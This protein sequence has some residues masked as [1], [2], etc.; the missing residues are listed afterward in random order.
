MILTERSCKKLLKKT[1]TS[2][3]IF[4]AVIKNLQQMLADRLH[5]MDA[6]IICYDIKKDQS[7]GTNYHKIM[8]Y[9]STGKVIVSNNV[10]TYKNESDFVMMNDERENNL[11]LPSLFK[12]IINDLN[13]YNNSSLQQ[14]RIAFAKNN[15]YQKQIERIEQKLQEHFIN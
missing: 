10:T 13:H 11:Q 7:K 8:E 2:F 14:K 15:T 5:Q 1:K 12:K 9:L 3:L 6:F 4:S